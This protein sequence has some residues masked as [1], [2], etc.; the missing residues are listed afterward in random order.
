MVCPTQHG[1]LKHTTCLTNLP[2]FEDSVTRG[3]DVGMPVKMFFHHNQNAG[4]GNWSSPVAEI[5]ILVKWIGKFS[6]GGTSHQ[7]LNETFSALHLHTKPGKRFQKGGRGF[8][9]TI[10]GFRSLYKPFLDYCIQAWSQLFQKDT[11]HLDEISLLPVCI[12]E[13]KWQRVCE[14]RISSLGLLSLESRNP[15]RSDWC[16]QDS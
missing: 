14:Q 7:L 9:G 4:L 5:G 1:L 15:G 13:V 12:T 6:T 3:I 8:Q 2:C 16:Y 10:W 11:N